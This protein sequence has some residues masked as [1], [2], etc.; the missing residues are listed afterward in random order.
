[1]MEFIDVKVSTAN[2]ESVTQFAEIVTSFTHLSKVLF[3]NFKM[4]PLPDEDIYLIPDIS[5]NSICEQCKGGRVEY[6]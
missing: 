2:F 5:V 6:K 3:P 1:M 4:I